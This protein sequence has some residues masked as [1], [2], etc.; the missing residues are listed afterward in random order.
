MNGGTLWGY[1]F[2]NILLQRPTVPPPSTTTRK[3][4]DTL[5]QG[6]YVLDHRKSTVKLR[7]IMWPGWMGVVTK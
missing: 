5:L 6:P 7:V 4:K 1:Q 2:N 3:D